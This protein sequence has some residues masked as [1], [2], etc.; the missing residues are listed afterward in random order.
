M[1]HWNEASYVDA[2]H[3]DDMHNTITLHN[4][5]SLEL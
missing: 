2:I 5:Q 3:V 1:E 4:R